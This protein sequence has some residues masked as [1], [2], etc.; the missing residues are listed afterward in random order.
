MITKYEGSW[1][2]FKSNEFNITNLT[3]NKKRHKKELSFNKYTP[4]QNSCKIHKNEKN[5]F[6]TINKFQQNKKII[7]NKK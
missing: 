2:I 5:D 1:N 4:N 6:K 3:K 7:L